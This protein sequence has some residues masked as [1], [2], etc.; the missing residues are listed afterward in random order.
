MAKTKAQELREKIEA[1]EAIDEGDSEEAQKYKKALAAL[2]GAS[3]PAGDTSSGL[4]ADSGLSEDDF[5]GIGVKLGRPDPGTYKAEAG[6][7]VDY[8]P[9]AYKI[10]VT[11]RAEGPWKGFD[12]DA[13]YPTKKPI[14]REDG[15][16]WWPLKDLAV[17]MG[18]EPRKA[19]GKVFYDLTDFAGKVFGAV[20]EPEA[21]RIE[22][23]DGRV[24]EGTT[25]KLKKAK[26]WHEGVEDLGV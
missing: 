21:Y 9:A 5:D 11:I 15:N 6:M 13:F 24:F 26:P 22:Q 14:K 16:L 4:V 17:A 10:P 2:E 12:Q 18:V 7:P 20:Y 19:K 8:S 25:S 23:E 1:L 3:E